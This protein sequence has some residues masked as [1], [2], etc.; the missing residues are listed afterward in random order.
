MTKPLSLKPQTSAFCQ[1]VCPFWVNSELFLKRCSPQTRAMSPPYGPV[2]DFAEALKHRQNKK[3]KQRQG[4]VSSVG[5]TAT[6]SHSCHCLSPRSFLPE[7]SVRLHVPIFGTAG[8]VL[9]QTPR[10]CSRRFVLKGWGT[11]HDQRRYGAVCLRPS[12]QRQGMYVCMHF[13]DGCMH[14]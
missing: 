14:E 3:Q 7:H 12:S 8:L 11:E 1:T 9:S 4:S 2:L 13:L 6:C 5:C 10:S